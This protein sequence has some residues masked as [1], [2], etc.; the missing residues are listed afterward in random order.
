MK[1]TDPEGAIKEVG[2]WKDAQIVAK[3]NRKN[4]VESSS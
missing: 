4:V 1:K 3:K 2:K